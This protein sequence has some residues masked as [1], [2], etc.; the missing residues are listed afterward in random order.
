MNDSEDVYLQNIPIVKENINFEVNDDFVTIKFAND[1]LLQRGFRKV[2]FKIPNTTSIQLD[3]YS[4]F[5]FLQID[6]KKNIY[7][8]GQQLKLSFEAECEPLY[9]RLVTFI[10]FLEDDRKWIL[11]TNKIKK[12]IVTII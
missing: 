3:E 9:E 6:G 4:S 2:G 11:F 5:I 1:H 7:E 12:K 10:D 8:I